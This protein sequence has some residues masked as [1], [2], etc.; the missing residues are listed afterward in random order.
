MNK[1]IDLEFDL[2]SF[3]PSS[4]SLL[5]TGTNPNISLNINSFDLLFMIGRLTTPAPQYPWDWR[6]LYAILRYGWVISNDSDFKFTQ[7]VMNIDFRLKALMSEDF[8]VGFTG[9]IMRDYFGCHFAGATSSIYYNRPRNTAIRTRATPDFIGIK[10]DGTRLIFESKGTQTSINHSN[11][12]INNGKINQVQRFQK[13]QNFP[14]FVIGS[15]LSRT[16]SAIISHIRVVD[17]YEEGNLTEG[18]NNSS[19]GDILKSHY[20]R[21][22]TFI[23]GIPWPNNIWNEIGLKDLL[24]KSDNI[25]FKEIEDGGWWYRTLNLPNIPNLPWIDNEAKAISVEIGLSNKVVEL[26][27]NGSWNEI[28]EYAKEGID[29]DSFLKESE[30]EKKNEIIWKNTY[31]DGMSAV[32]RLVYD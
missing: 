9:L 10:L 20:Y 18:I 30:Q 7:D 17:P 28:L 1:K 22:G 29:L 16:G 14:G 26:V 27:E 6:N 12:Q 24:E 19:V 13:F 32:V 5:P 15:L 25:V 3:S 4:L 8:G 21:L 23:S 31:K 2:G 11:N